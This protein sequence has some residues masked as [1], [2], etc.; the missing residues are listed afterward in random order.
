MSTKSDSDN[1]N[2]S[3][4]DFVEICDYDVI[5]NYYN[6]WAQFILQ[7]IDYDN[8]EFKLTE[9]EAYDKIEFM[10]DFIT[11]LSDKELQ[12][13]VIAI[14]HLGDTFDIERTIQYVKYCNNK[15]K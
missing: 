6:E 5:N 3:E 14:E 9:D 1:D 13:M 4:V 10:E 8:T 12:T 2:I 11:E 15:K 7:K